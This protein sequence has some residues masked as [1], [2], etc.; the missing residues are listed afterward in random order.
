MHKLDEKALTAAHCC[1]AILPCSWQRH[2]GMDSVCPTCQAATG[3]S[4]PSPE[5][6]AAQQPA[7][8]TEGQRLKRLMEERWSRQGGAMDYHRKTRWTTRALHRDRNLG[9]H[10]LDLREEEPN[11]PAR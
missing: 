9:G 2:N 6:S 8:E 10:L 1:S 7:T 3:A 4:L 5:Q 11:V